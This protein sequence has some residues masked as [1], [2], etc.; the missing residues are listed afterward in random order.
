[1]VTT[2]ILQIED[3]TKFQQILNLAKRLKIPF[4][5]DKA[6]SVANETDNVV[7]HWDDCDNAAYELSLET[8]AEDWNSDAD[9]IWDT[10]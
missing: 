7:W 6:P 9:K 3:A 10:I 1:M 5:F 2:L 4:R 8:F